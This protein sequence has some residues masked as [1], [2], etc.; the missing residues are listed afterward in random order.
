MATKQE[1]VRQRIQFAFNADSDSVVGCVF[2]YLLKDQHFSSR[3]GKRKGVDAIVAFY[4]PFAYQAQAD[5]SEDELQ[6][7]ARDAVE[8]LCRQIDLLC[9]TFG[10]E[11]P[12]A[13]AHDVKTEIKQMLSELLIAE[14]VRVHPEIP[15]LSSVDTIPNVLPPT[16]MD[17]NE[18]INCDIDALLGDLCSSAEAAA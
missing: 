6:T 11:R 14:L 8:A 2:Q 18:E 10:I 12:A 4:K 5:V 15:G 9:S 13:I 3:E 7:I 16:D 17:I 1:A